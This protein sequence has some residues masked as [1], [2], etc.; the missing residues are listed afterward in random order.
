MMAGIGGK[1]TKPEV[2]VRSFLHRLG[3]RF[4]IHSAALPGRPDLVFPKYRAVVFVHGCFW[5]RHKGC[6]YAYT[7]KS[8][9]P[10][11]EKKFAENVA[12]DARN[13]RELRQAGWKVL[14]VWECETRSEQRLTRA[15]QRISSAGESR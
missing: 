14:T 13:A 12:R 5:H 1:N 9:L 3:L 2:R 6:R 15:A 11:W 7:P 4:R 8:N 10:F